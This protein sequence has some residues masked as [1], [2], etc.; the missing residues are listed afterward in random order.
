M[1]IL[2]VYMYALQVQQRTFFMDHL[3]QTCW[4]EPW[5]LIL[6]LVVLVMTFFMA[7]LVMISSMVTM[8]TTPFLAQAVMTRW[9]APAATTTSMAATAMI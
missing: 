2:M 1:V 9:M 3:D 7:S 4:S 8:V 5:A 6:C